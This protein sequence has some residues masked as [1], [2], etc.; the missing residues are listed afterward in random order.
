MLLPADSRFTRVTAIQT[1]AMIT[2]RRNQGPLKG[3]L[4]GFEQKYV[5]PAPLIDPIGKIA[6]EW[7]GGNRSHKVND[8]SWKTQF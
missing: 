4:E 6:K 5:F 8:P 2:C 1:V 7:H 3:K